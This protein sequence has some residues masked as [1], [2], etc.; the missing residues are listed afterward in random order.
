M[1]LK[2]IKRDGY[3]TVTLNTGTSKNGNIEKKWRTKEKMVRSNLTLK[4][5]HFSEIYLKTGKLFFIGIPFVKSF[6]IL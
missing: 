3:L 1:K 5:P 6:N 2:H 4:V